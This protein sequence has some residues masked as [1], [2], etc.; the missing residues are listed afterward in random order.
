MFDTSKNS[1]NKLQ[2]S[3]NKDSTSFITVPID[4]GTETEDEN[5]QS[6]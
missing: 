3:R 2:Q 5:H 1:N 4:P 6:K